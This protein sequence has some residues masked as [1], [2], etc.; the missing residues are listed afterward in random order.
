M[1]HEKTTIVLKRLIQHFLNV[2]INKNKMIIGV[3]WIII[4]VFGLKILYFIMMYVSFSN[5]HSGLIE[6]AIIWKLHKLKI[7]LHQNCCEIYRNS[8]MHKHRR[9]IKLN[10]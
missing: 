1:S 6:V 3:I 8:R 2:L 10:F 5:W 7:F 4:F 9:N